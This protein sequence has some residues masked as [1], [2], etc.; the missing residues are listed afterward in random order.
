MLIGRVVWGIA[1]AILLGLAGKTFAFSAFIL[2]GVL[3]ETPGIVIQLVL[4]P[5]IVG[6]IERK[7]MAN[8]KSD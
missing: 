8:I 2:G 5:L 6:L 1:Q 3:Y 4:I 7:H